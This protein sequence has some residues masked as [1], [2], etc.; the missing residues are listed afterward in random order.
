MYMK[1]SLS[2]LPG[3]RDNPTTRALQTAKNMYYEH[4]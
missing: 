2:K 1:F 3:R 4:K